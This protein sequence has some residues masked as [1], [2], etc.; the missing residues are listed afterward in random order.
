MLFPRFLDPAHKPIARLHHF[1][2]VLKAQPVHLALRRR[3]TGK[4]AA[5]PVRDRLEQRISRRLLGQRRR[6]LASQI[7]VVAVDCGY[8]L[9][10]ARLGVLAQARRIALQIARAHRHRITVHRL[11]GGELGCGEGWA[12][13]LWLG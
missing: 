13:R 12:S 7:K 5:R 6:L 3:M 11:D 8:G 4:R 9:C 2:R 10:L 1:V